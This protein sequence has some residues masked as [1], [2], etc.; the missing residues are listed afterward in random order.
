MTAMC[1]GEYFPNPEAFADER[2]T[3]AYNAVS[4]GKRAKRE[5][6]RE[7]ERRQVKPIEW[8]LLNRSFVLTGH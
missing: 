8:S 2:K 7:R 4:H 1:F 3:A 5:R 6:E